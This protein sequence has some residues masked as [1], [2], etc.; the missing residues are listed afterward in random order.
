MFFTIEIGLALLD[1]DHTDQFRLGQQRDTQ[2]RKIIRRQQR[3]E[4]A[5]LAHIRHEQRPPGGDHLFKQDAILHRHTQPDAAFAV[6]KPAGIRHRQH[7]A[8]SQPQG[9]RIIRQHRRQAFQQRAHQFFGLQTGGDGA[10]HLG[11]RLELDGALAGRLVQTGIFQRQSGLLGQV[12]GQRLII[13][14]ERPR[15]GVVIQNQ[16]TQHTLGQTQR[17]QQ[18][19]NRQ[20]PGG[21]LAIMQQVLRA[22]VVILGKFN[23]AHDHRLPTLIGTQRQGQRP[24]VL[25]GALQ[26]EAN[27]Q[28]AGLIDKTTRRPR[29]QLAVLLFPQRHPPGVGLGDGLERGFHQR[30]ED[31]VDVQG[32]QLAG[33][34]QQQVH[35]LQTAARLGQQLQVLQSNT[36]LARH[37][38][39]DLAVLSSE[40]R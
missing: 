5:V 28:H 21:G 23:L 4:T 15:L 13:F 19:G 27:R 38:M 24:G 18:A 36:D 14:A 33:V 37:L 2:P 39:I 3:W 35:L 10:G 31:A 9:G 30:I 32:G 11:Q 25:V 6:G 29:H 17:Q 1:G 12:E 16:N 7:V 22:Q 26:R 40:R 8:A 20:M 34:I